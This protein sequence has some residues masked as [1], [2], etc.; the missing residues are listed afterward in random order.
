[1]GKGLKTAKDDTNHVIIVAVTGKGMVNVI[2][3]QE[4]Y[5]KL[6]V[7]PDF[8]PILLVHGTKSVPC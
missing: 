8:G 6:G 3:L 5:I 1:V 7:M 2:G 4:P